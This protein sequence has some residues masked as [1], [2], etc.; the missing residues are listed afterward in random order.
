MPR[1]KKTPK[2]NCKIF[3]KTNCLAVCCRTQTFIMRIELILSLTFSPIQ[4]LLA[5]P[6]HGSWTLGRTLLSWPGSLL[7]TM[8]EET[9]WDTMLRRYRKW[10]QYLTLGCK[11][12]CWKFCEFFTW[13]CDV[14]TLISNHRF[15]SERKNG[16]VAQSS[17]VKSWHTL[18]PV[19]PKEQIIMSVSSQSTMPALEL[20]VWL[21]LSRS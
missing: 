11:I 10:V 8:V 3:P 5:H 21:N 1:P 2:K 16:L 12:T 20:L 18:W 15:W 17:G 6:H 13:N 4:C 7:C 14:K 19:W 9:S